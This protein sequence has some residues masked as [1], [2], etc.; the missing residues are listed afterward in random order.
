[1]REIDLNM[2]EVAFAAEIMTVIEHGKRNA[3]CIVRFTQERGAASSFHRVIDTMNTV[4]DSR[5]LVV[6][7]KS[8]RKMMIKT[9]NA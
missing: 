3:L 6:G 7:D 2:K 1:V 4:F 8:K 5:N 9:L